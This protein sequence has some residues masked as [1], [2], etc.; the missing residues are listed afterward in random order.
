MKRISLDYMA[1]KPGTC[2]ICG[3]RIFPGMFVFDVQSQ[4]GKRGVVH[5]LCE[6]KIVKEGTK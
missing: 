1:A 6:R 2:K 4:K 5:A 3:N